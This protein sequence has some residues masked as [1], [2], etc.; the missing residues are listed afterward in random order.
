V[1]CRETGEQ[2]HDNEIR[3]VPQKR[4]VARINETRV[5]S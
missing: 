2:L 4:E 1:T 5:S 3:R